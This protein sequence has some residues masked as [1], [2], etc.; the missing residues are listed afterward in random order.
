M[1]SG[2]GGLSNPNRLVLATLRV[3]QFRREPAQHQRPHRLPRF[4]GKFRRMET[5]H[6]VRNHVWVG[7]Q[8]RRPRILTETE[9]MPAQVQ[10][11]APDFTAT[12]VVNEEFNDKF[13]LSDY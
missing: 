6:S 5:S 12:A 11:E 7:R 8:Q 2:V 1:G 4:V 10:K 9:P 13:K 3:T